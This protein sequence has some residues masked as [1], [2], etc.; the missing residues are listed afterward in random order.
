VCGVASK[1]QK[2]KK[3]RNKK[4]KKV[5]LKICS[6]VL[7]SARRARDPAAE[8]WRSCSLALSRSSLV[9]TPFQFQSRPADHEETN[10]VISS[11]RKLN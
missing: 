11:K 6:L 7:I 10:R 8:D 1:Y 4:K 2:K 5:E 9:F 3:I